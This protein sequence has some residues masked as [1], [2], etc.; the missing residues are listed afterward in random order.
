M[1]RPRLYLL[2]PAPPGSEWAPFAGARPLAELRAGAWRIRERWAR[3]LG[4]EPVA[5][6]S[7][8]TPDF[9]D[10][11]SIPVLPIGGVAGPAVIAA[12][13]FAPLGRGLA[14]EQGITRLTA[15]GR[16]VAWVVSGGETWAGRRDEG[17]AVPIEGMELRGSFDL[18]TALEELLGG[19]CAVSA[20]EGGEGVPAGSTV[21]GDPDLLAVR[22]A[23]VEP[24]VVFDLRKGAVVLEEG[25]LIRSGARLEG[26]LYVGPHSWILGGPVRHSAV[27]P[28]CRVHGEVTASVFLGYANK[29]HDGFVGHSVLGQWV[30]LGAGTITS[31]LKNTY[32][33]VRLDLP[34]RRLG[35]GR[36][37][38]GTL[39][40]D[41]SKTAIGTMLSTGT[42][43][44]T[45]ANVVGAPPVP[46]YLQPFAWATAGDQLLDQ[47]GFLK[48]AG[49]VLPRR[50]VGLTPA[51][52]AS[53]RAVH[54]R[55]TR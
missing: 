40:G 33:E 41:H 49:R 35:T 20:A 54:Q 34:D 14:L 42:V 12:S 9:A 51:I 1:T 18:V 27:G 6:L 8:A 2:E 52:T 13:W 4:L 3:L 28:H 36:M 46:R 21:L 37:N 48:I 24:G 11:D 10:A 45:G 50:G 26:P 5:V 16:T 39:F 38:L 15:G 23:E 22:G 44:G 32:G 17:A 29:S 43:V 25:A 55:L 47:E 30:N 19:D 31:N 7:D 53:L